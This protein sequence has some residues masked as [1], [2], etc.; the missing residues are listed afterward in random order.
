MQNNLRIIDPLYGILR[1]LDRMQPYRLEMATRNVFGKDDTTKLNDLWKESVTQQLARELA[2]RP[3]SDQQILLNLASDE[4]AAAVDATMLQEAAP[5]SKYVKVVFRDQGRVVA[6]HAKRARGLMVRFVAET[7]AKTLEDVQDFDA[8][9]YKLVVKESDEST[10]VFDRPKQIASK[11][12]SAKK[13]PAAKGQKRA[14]SATKK[15][16][17]TEEAK[18]RG[19]KTTSWHTWFVDLDLVLR[20]RETEGIFNDCKFTK[21]GMQY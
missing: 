4:Y 15:E 12:P 16:A 2:L 6:V 19:R 9:G 18:K 14:A 5:N 3:R 20:T 11:M 7:Q 17:T 21:L 13:A 1:P 8:E 10:L